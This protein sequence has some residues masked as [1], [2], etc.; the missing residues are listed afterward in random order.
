MASIYIA[1]D[2]DGLYVDF[3]PIRFVNGIVRVNQ[4][5]T[6]FIPSDSFSALTA[7]VDGITPPLAIGR[8]AVFDQRVDGYSDAACDL[9]SVPQ[10]NVLCTE[11]AHRLAPLGVDAGGCDATGD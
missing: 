7:L 3:E 5:T 6:R 9:R 10:T 8:V 1:R 11:S 2:V 4:P